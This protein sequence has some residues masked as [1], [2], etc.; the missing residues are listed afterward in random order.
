[1]LEVD[2]L[3][4]F[5]V[6]DY[7]EDELVGQVDHGDKTREK[8]TGALM[9]RVGDNGGCDTHYLGHL[10]V[11]HS[12]SGFKGSRADDMPSTDMTRYP[13]SPTHRLPPFAL[14]IFWRGLMSMSK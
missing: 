12:F 14:D 7:L 10:R 5:E 3:G 1:V 13:F 2:E 6:R 8:R 11:P 4:G 9:L